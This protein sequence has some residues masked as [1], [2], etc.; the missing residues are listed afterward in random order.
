MSTN[1]SI[2]TSGHVCLCE[3]SG[4][5]TVT[6]VVSLLSHLQQP[7]VLNRPLA[8]ELPMAL[9]HHGDAPAPCVTRPRSHLAT[10]TTQS[11]SPP[12]QAGDDA[13]ATVLVINLHPSSARCILSRSSTFAD[14]LPALWAYCQE[15]IIACQDEQGLINHLR[16]ALCGSASTPIA[17]LARPLV[18]FEL[19]DEAFDHAQGVY[20]HD[21]LELRRRRIRSGTWATDADDEV[22]RE[23]S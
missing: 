21:V 10:C 22:A 7:T 5:V 11:E 19:L 12:K 9:P 4:P 14:V 18:F 8:A 6:M 2:S 17:T 13:A 15:I 16:R 3:W 1:A 20:P 23:Q